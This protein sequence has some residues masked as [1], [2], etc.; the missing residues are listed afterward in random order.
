MKV[1]NILAIAALGLID[2][3]TITKKYRLLSKMRKPSYSNEER[4]KVSLFR[5]RKSVLLHYRIRD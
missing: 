3:S 2:S 5:L 1:Q 4:R